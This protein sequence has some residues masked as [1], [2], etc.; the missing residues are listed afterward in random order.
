MLD[1]LAI[2]DQVFS[3][4]L[5]IGFSTLVS[6]LNQVAQ[7]PFHPVQSHVLN[8]ILMCV[9]DCPGV[10]SI[11]QIEELGLLLTKMLERHTDG[12]MGMLPE[13][14]NL[15]CN[16]SVTL[17]KTPS[18]AGVANFAISVKKAIEHAVS[19]CLSSHGDPNNILFSLY[20]LKEAYGYC[21]LGN[22]PST[23]FVE[24]QRCILDVCKIHLLPW[25]IEKLHDLQS[26]EI[27]MGILETF[28]VIMLQSSGNENAEFARNLV[29][30]SWFSFSF[31]CMGL[32]PTESMRL[33]VFMLVG[34]LVDALLSEGSGQ[35]VKD[36]ASELPS[37]PRE[38]L[39]I[40]RQRTGSNPQLA[41][42]QNAALLIFYISSLYN[43]R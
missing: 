7:V 5:P 1:I 18:S 20:F 34:I 42:C 22:S 6:I 32:Y 21:Q 35:P 8:L 30:S 12:E 36:S 27:V 15:V 24:L 10:I 19:A 43:E 14:F 11:H 41:Y 28:H 25:I 4:R 13:T 39:F 16:L 38:L 40:L 29:S 26:E 2:A 37:D 31:E 33:R 9:S 17:M 3:Q 23:E